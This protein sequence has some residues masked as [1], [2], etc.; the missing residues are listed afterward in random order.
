M[1]DTG[2]RQLRF[3]MSMAMGRSISVTNIHRL[4]SDLLATRAEFGGLRRDQIEEMLGTPLD[5]EARRLMDARRWRKAVHRRTA[6]PSTTGG[7]S[8]VS[9]RHRTS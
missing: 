9:A 4:V 1:L 3:G 2:L 6:A 5:P 7:R 8:T